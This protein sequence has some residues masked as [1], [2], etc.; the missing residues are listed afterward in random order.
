MSIFERNA[1]SR[2]DVVQKTQA[3]DAARAAVAQGKANLAAAKLDLSYTHIYAPIAGRIDRNLVDAGNL[4]GAGDATLLASIVSQDPIYAY[5][6][7]S[8]RDLRFDQVV[9]DRGQ[10]V[11]SDIPRVSGTL[12][13]CSDLQDV[14]RLETGGDRC[15]PD[16]E[17]RIGHSAFD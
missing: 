14:R 5:F 1:G 17:A 3:R 4:V 11:R 9:F 7:V 6:D 13:L 10:L 15:R 8:E 2:T 16:E 12:G